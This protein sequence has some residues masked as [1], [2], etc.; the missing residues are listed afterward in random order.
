MSRKI[1]KYPQFFNLGLVTQTAANAA[2][3]QAAATPIPRNPMT[4]NKSRVMEI[5]KCYVYLSDWEN[6]AATTNLD[7]IMALSTRNLTGLGADAIASDPST[8]A[9]WRF[10]ED[11]VQGAAGRTVINR[12][13]GWLEMDLQSADG[14]GF[15]V[16]TDQ[17]YFSVRTAAFTA[18][19]SFHCRVLYRF[20]DVNLTEYIGIVQGQQ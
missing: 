1:D 8:F 17:I 10:D 12:S 13:G 19:R 5:I 14:Y 20:A 2:I 15:L 16:A 6:F 4:T 7:V 9:C 11:T 18:A 3:N